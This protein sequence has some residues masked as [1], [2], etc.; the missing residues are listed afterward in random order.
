MVFGTCCSALGEQIRKTTKNDAIADCF[1]GCLHK[2]ERRQFLQFFQAFES[3]MNTKEGNDEHFF[4]TKRK[5]VLGLVDS[6]YENKRALNITVD[7][8]QKAIIE[9]TSVSET[10]DEKKNSSNSDENLKGSNSLTDD[11][12]TYVADN[13]SQLL[14]QTAYDLTFNGDGGIWNRHYSKSV[15]DQFYAYSQ[16][17]REQMQHAL[18]QAF[19]IV[20]D[21]DWNGTYV[22]QL[23]DLI[24]Y[25][26]VKMADLL[27]HNDEKGSLL[28]AK[29][30]LQMQQRAKKEGKSMD[31]IWDS[32]MDI[33]WKQGLKPEILD[34]KSQN[35]CQ[36]T[37]KNMKVY[38]EKLNLVYK[39]LRDYKSP[40]TVGESIV[41][42]LFG[43][44]KTELAK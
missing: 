8:V 41:Q 35:K 3:K 16:T 10:N 19:F 5:Y 39:G 26:D 43:F 7:K 33:A 11:I 34:V 14:A 23:V 44:V 42:G 32:Y 17:R 24:L 40:P 37:R 6:C 18:N 38:E 2:Q 20:F 25:D 30:Q 12:K 13:H 1:V 27:A 22:D 36:Y 31:K 29:A 28:L 9:T 21:R 4:G 15:V